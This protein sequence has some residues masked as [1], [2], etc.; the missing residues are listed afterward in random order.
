ML[1]I[2]KQNIMPNKNY[3]RMELEW[4]VFIAAKIAR[5][6]ISITQ[7]AAVNTQ[8]GKRTALRSDV[9]G[10]ATSWLLARRE[11]TLVAGAALRSAA[12]TSRDH[13]GDA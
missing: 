2:W 6:D 3:F 10:Q 8:A 12:H 7:P 4:R 11:V 1:N 13:A 9:A 5:K